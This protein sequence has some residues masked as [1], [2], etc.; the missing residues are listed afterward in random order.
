MPSSRLWCCPLFH[1]VLTDVRDNRDQVREVPIN[2]LNPTR[3]IQIAIGEQE[4]WEI[5]DI[6][7]F[8]RGFVSGSEYLS[9]IVEFDGP[10]AWGELRW[11]GFRSEG[12]RVQL[13]TRTGSD[14]DPV[15]YWRYIGRGNDRGEVTGAE[16]EKLKVGERAGTTYDRS[17]WSFWSA[18]Y[19]FVDS[20]GARVVSPSPRRYFQFKVDLEPGE[21]GGELH[22]LELETWPPLAS[23]LV[24]EVWPVD[25]EVGEWRE[26]SYVL[27]PTIVAGDSGFDRLEITSPALFGEVRDVRIGDVPVSWELEEAD[28]HRFLLS[29]PHLQPSD[30]GVLVEVSFDAQVLRY[31]STFDG[32]VWISDSTPFTPQRVNPGDAS[33]EFEGD[34]LSVATSVRDE[35]LLR[36]EFPDV[37]TPNGDGVGDWV[38]LTYE[39]YEVIG[40]STVHVEIFDLAGRRVLRLHEGREGIG[41]YQRR[42]DGRDEN[43]RL[44]PPGLYLARVELSTDEADQARRTEVIHIAY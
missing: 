30:S 42:F 20:S 18:P 37:L 14:P 12:A 11:S 43:G 29:L 8:G 9:N 13:Q 44:L 7:V 25:S 17:S 2:A 10:M 16:Y 31:G 40:E 3:F 36:A 4:G 19:D 39:I 35:T 23:A 27:R 1:P 5:H 22:R 38:L 24:G 34:R 28:S 33:G 6:Q 21:E 41:R 26:Y 32:R 15:R